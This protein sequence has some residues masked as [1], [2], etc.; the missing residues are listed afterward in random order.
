MTREGEERKKRNY[1]RRFGKVT[2][3]PNTDSTNYK[4][5]EL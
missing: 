4:K 1:R 3:S 5:R 2:F